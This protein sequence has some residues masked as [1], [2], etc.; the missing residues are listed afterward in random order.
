[1]NTTINYGEYSLAVVSEGDLLWVDFEAIAPLLGHSDSS[2]LADWL[3]DPKLE[4]NPR[5]KHLKGKYIKHFDGSPMLAFDAFV[6]IVQL[7][8]RTNNTAFDLLTSGFA[9]SFYSLAK[10]QIGEELSTAQRLAY[11]KSWQE[12]LRSCREMSY[13][14]LEGFIS[15]RDL[16]PDESEWRRIEHLRLLSQGK[17]DPL[18]S[19]FL[20]GYGQAMLEAKRAPV[21]ERSEVNRREMALWVAKADLS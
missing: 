13:E 15:D 21:N 16:H 8:S 7:E 14:E 11:L 1:M 10:A 12:I 20:G 2:L 4:R 5:L 17:G 19:F 18:R 9:E 3:E 6:L